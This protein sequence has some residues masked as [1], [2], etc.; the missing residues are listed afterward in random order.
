MKLFLQQISKSQFNNIPENERNFF[1][2]I[3]HLANEIAIL[4]KLFIM[5]FKNKSSSHQVEDRA[6]MAQA[7]FIMKIL[8]GKVWEAWE[9]ITKVF[10]RSLSNKYE[11][12]LPCNA[13]DTLKELKL[14]F[15]NKTN[16][17]IYKIR[18]KFSFHYDHGMIKS[19]F[20][21]LPDDLKM[22]IYYEE[23]NANSLYYG[24]EVFVNSAMLEM[25][26]PGNQQ[27]AID[28]LIEETNNVSNLLIDFIGNC[29]FLF[30]SD[31]FQNEEGK[32]YLETVDVGKAPS[33]SEIV[34]PYF[35]IR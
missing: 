14:Y 24:S 10:N 29:M 22:D 33:I 25:I 7:L 6:H 35:V 27:K 3:G 18:N 32:I 1:L 31:F 21:K 13:K 5:S 17:V 23:S 9:L 15:S 12:R 34:I 20:N 16:T 2:F 26:Y 11:P 8:V 30:V 19:I 28:C 4:Q